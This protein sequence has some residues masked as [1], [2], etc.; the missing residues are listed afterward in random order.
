MN[1][2]VKRIVLL[3]SVA[4]LVLATL[5]GFSRLGSIYRMFHPYLDRDVVGATSITSEWLEIIPKEP[6]H[7]ERQ[8]QYLVLDVADPFE[9]VYEVWSLRLRDGSL[10]KPEAQLVDESGNVFD[11]TSPALDTKGLALRNSNLPVDRIYPKVR[12]RSNKTIRVSRIFW[13]CYNQWDLK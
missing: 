2:I 3:V 5:I 8:V 4:C 6:L 7:V 11:L 13:R 12:I 9:P 1:R 10:V